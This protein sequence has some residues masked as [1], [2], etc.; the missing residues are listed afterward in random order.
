MDSFD[1]HLPDRAA[2]EVDPVA[3]GR[4]HAAESS[5]VSTT[6][7][8]AHRPKRLLRI[9][10]F[11]LLGIVVL[12]AVG[13]ITAHHWL[14]AAVRDSLP[15][16]DGTLA[17]PG[18]SADVTVQRDAHGVPHIRAHSLD[19]LVFA[20]GYITAQDR[21]WQMETLRRHAAGTLA[22]I[23]GSSLIEHD[24]TQ[25]VL[26]LR[27]SADR[28]LAV[29]PSDQL[30]WLE[31]YARGVNASID[32]QRQHLPV[33]FRILGFSPAPWT[34]RDSLLVGLVMF[35][36]LTNSFPEKLGRE[37]ITSKLSPDLL[38]DL[39]PVGSWRDHPVV[40][41][42]VDLT[43]PQTDFEDIPLDK[44]QTKLTRPA[45]PALATPQHIQALL[46]AKADMAPFTS[47]TCDGCAAGS[48]DWV[49]S[50][51]RTASGKPLLSNDMHLSHGVPGIWYEADLKAPTPT[52]E[53]HVAGVSLP[54]TP[55]IIVGHNDHIAW[56]FTNLGADV[57]DLTIERL[58]G[59]GDSAE[60]Q[61]TDGTW[62]PLLHQHEIIRVHSGHNVTLDI[63]ETRHGAITTPIIS[64]LY[65]SEKRP[66]SLRWTIYDPTTVT[67]PFFAVNSA[68]D[69]VSLVDAFSTFGGPSQNMVYADDQGH[70]GY[71][72]VGRIPLRGDPAH[73][74]SPSPVPADASVTANEWSTAAPYIPFD[75]LPHVEDPPGGIL[76]TANARI[77]PDDYPY[78][79]T[80]DWAAPYRN[81]RIWK[82]LAA[83]QNLTPADML[84]LQTD[85]SSDLDRVVAQRLAYAID[86]AT[87]PS[88]KQKRLHQAADILRGW[89]G[90]V[91]ANASA[92]AIVDAT[93]TA[94]W[95]LL[96]TPKL[97]DAQKLYSWGEK[98]FA[99]EQLIMHTPTRWLPSTYASWDALL[100][101]A[102]EQGLHDEHAP[103]DLTTWH[104]GKVHP[105]DIE[106][107]IFSSTPLLQHLLGL[108][109]GTGPLPQS[110]DTSTV[111]QVGKTFG[112]S[113][114]FTADLSNLDHS[115]LNV[116]L[117]QSGNPA[118]PWFMDQFQAWYT[119]KTF[120]FPYTDAA[121]QSSTTHTLILTPQ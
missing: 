17:V 118:S 27:A 23:L 16:I 1:S 26:Q 103:S 74:T 114:R 3:L 66:I 121:V 104:Y 92:P 24:R 33:E 110:G 89:N 54:G 108:P 98:S 91:D 37:T 107:P 105:V 52:G 28:A 78:P 76:A 40:Q 93:R 79:I 95:P 72:A 45:N 44:S 21:L 77:V 34:P 32:V 29:L 14:R 81:E 117:G 38:A 61:A 31:L 70:I 6:P 22:E 13:Y 4:R 57:Q 88:G 8:P 12:G 101:D 96:L 41:P 69:G 71:H 86:H 67:S 115:T 111:K 5:H 47:N 11:V 46:D 35:E 20:Q 63:P 19:D 100:V 73:P 62:Q 64:G 85:I 112:P 42:L 113:E 2:S 7:S 97:G 102:V 116:V 10:S 99:E 90:T 65:P 30:H 18:L 58:R 50:G 68:T 15:Q 60:F 83:K 43:Q 75:Q 25:R 56:G 80:L 84:T 59:S 53:F 119:G 106:H 120:P 36:D 94:L 51:A 9:L 39:Y 55:F 82:V 109:T 49:V 87:I 48:N